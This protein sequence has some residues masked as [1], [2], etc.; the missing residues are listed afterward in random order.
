MSFGWD[1]RVL[2]EHYLKQQS[3][4]FLAPGTGF[5]EDSFS[6]D[7]GEDKIYFWII[8]AHYIYCVFYFYYYYIRSSGMRSQRLEAPEKGQHR[9][10][11]YWSSGH[12]LRD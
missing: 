12:L 3:S 5:V 7:M 10:L 2:Q 9:E 1:T 8:Q 11:Y 6:M 4:T